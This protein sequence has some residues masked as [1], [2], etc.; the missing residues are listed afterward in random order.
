MDRRKFIIST[1]GALSSEFLVKTGS[2][3]LTPQGSSDVA[4]TIARSEKSY[5]IPQTFTGLSYEMSQL[6][7]PGFFSPQNKPLV[8]YFRSLGVKG[9]LRLGGGTVDHT[10]WRPEDV[11]HSDSDALA[12]GP[13]LTPGHRDTI[14]TKA[15][16]RNLVGFL[17]ATGWALI[18]G[19]NFGHGTI[20]RAV[21]EAEY[22]YQQAGKHLIAMQIGNEPDAYSKHG[23]RPSEWGV[24]NFLNEWETW[25][26]A[27]LQRVPNCPL[28]G[29]D[30]AGRNEWFADFAEREHGKVTVLTSHH[31]AEGPPTDPSMN[32][33]RLLSKSSKLASKFGE[34]VAIS[35]KVGL[36]YRMAEGNSCYHEGKAGVSDTFASG[37]WGADFMLATAQLGVA[38]VNFHGGGEGY[39]TPVAASP[40]GAYSAR[41]LYYGMLLC[42][43]FCGMFIVPVKLSRGN[44]NVSA[45][46]VCDDDSNIQVAIIN[47]ET[48]VAA[49]VR[50]S[51]GGKELQGTQLDLRAPSLES[52]D[53]VTFGGSSVTGN[54]TWNPSQQAAVKTHGGDLTLT[55][56]A[57]SAT[58][59]KLKML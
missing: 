27:I 10:V 8:Q 30:V 5:R 1:V 57:A 2:A 45:Y 9:V 34:F 51:F 28:G 3:Q 4:F 19:L 46:A 13:G 49:N 24:A 17:D 12:V 15:A 31:Y 55:L 48:N 53:G 56:P 32:I 52:K 35:S 36:P 21:D 29:P 23:M 44:A 11:T 16:I 43:E 6:E 59:L 20:E 42:R 33:E 14:V 58:L 50:L 40:N 18:Y 26:K 54:G 7:H 37:L 39:Y 25:A 41:P 47:K 22:V 38:G